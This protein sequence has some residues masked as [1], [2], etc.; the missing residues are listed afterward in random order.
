MS[1]ANN[2]V[3]DDFWA[4]LLP[5]NHEYDSV[6]EEDFAPERHESLIPRIGALAL[7]VLCCIALSVAGWAVR[8]SAAARRVAA[9][10][11][12]TIE[13]EIERAGKEA[14]L[15]RDELAGERKQRHLVDEALT[16]AAARR[17]IQGRPAP[18]QGW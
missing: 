18:R 10:A 13:N 3:L 8:D 12:A 4:M 15:V 5:E 1:K 6:T 9:K 17:D 14:I 16:K 2:S 7:I 11:R